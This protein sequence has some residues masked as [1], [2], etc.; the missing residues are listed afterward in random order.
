M[1]EVESI[2]QKSFEEAQEASVF[3]QKMICIN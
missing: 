1:E 3:Y 2:P